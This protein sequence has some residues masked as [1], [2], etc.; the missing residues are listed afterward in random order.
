MLLKVSAVL[1]ALAVPTSSAAPNA[2]VVWE[3]CAGYTSC[4]GC[5][6]GLCFVDRAGCAEI[7]SGSERDD[8]MGRDDCVGCTGCAKSA[9]DGICPANRVG[10]AERVGGGIVD[11]VDDSCRGVS[12]MCRDAVCTAGTLRGRA[13]CHSWFLQGVRSV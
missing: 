7:V 12:D 10:C 4:A 1:T 6:G 9:E 13:D 5:E 3:V 11:S 8:G 2:S